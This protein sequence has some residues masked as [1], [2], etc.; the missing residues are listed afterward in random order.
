MPPCFSS[1][2]KCIEV[3]NYD[4]FEDELFTLKILLKNAIALDELVLEGYFKIN[5]GIF[6]YLFYEYYEEKKYLL[7]NYSNNWF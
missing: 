2:L 6:S 3:G 7:S 5:R 4:G 1:Y